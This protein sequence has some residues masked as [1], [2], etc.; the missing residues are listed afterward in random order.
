MHS[1]L[2]HR[3][4]TKQPLL[5]ALAPMDGITDYSFRKIMRS[6][7]PNIITYS[8]FI[9]VSKLANKNQPK[10]MFDKADNPF[11]VQIF[12]NEPDNFAKASHYLSKL[13]VAGIDINMGCSSRKIASSQ[14]GAFLMKDV[15]K[16]CQ[17]ISACKKE[18]SLPITVKTRL[19]WEDD[20][21]L[22]DFI[23]EL[24][25]SGIDMVTIHG[26]TYKQKF[27]S[28][29]SFAPIY[30]LKAALNITVIGNGDIKCYEDGMKKLNN[31]N[32]FMIGRSALQDPW[33][34]YPAV[35]RAQVSIQDRLIT[36]LKHFKI[37]IAS[38]PPHVAQL[39]I[40]KYLAGY[41]KGMADSKNFSQQLMAT[42]EP[43]LFIKKVY[44]KLA[45]IA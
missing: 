29:A 45:E 16:A 18:T 32:G 24:M 22:I 42:K 17:I 19:G 21:K 9:N 1:N 6:L 3:L 5:I 31:L 41:L 30:R 8:E 39:Q 33:V 37:K 35:K 34:F 26:R 11:F 7:H 2:N 43:N 10:L 23:A 28:A 13:N 12:G 27:K 40:R 15:K 4:T 14:H 36:L 44:N 20:S 25:N 38:Q